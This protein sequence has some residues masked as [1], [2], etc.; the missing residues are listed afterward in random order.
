MAIAMTRQADLYL[1]RLNFFKKYPC[2]DK[3]NKMACA[4]SEDS[5]QPGLPPSLIRVFAVCSMG[6]SKD[7]S[8]LHA[9]SRDP[10][11][12]GR[13]PRLIWVFPGRTVILLVLSW[14]GSDLYF[15]GP[16]QNPS[17]L[18]K[19]C[20]I[21]SKMYRLNSKMSLR[22]LVVVNH[23]AMLYPKTLL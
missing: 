3:T 18:S 11:E 5:D 19:P 14:G 8:F 7:P 6:N 15:W 17:W 1:C 12:T 9:D 16:N 13:M 20:W 21:E 23:L 4:P 10:D 2:H 22:Y